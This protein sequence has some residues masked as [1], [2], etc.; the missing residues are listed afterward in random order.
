M[1]VSIMIFGNGMPN[2]LHI[3]TQVDINITDKQEAMIL[4][5]CLDTACLIAGE[6]VATVREIRYGIHTENAE[7]EDTAKRAEIDGQNQSALS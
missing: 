2:P 1:I 7:Q 5:T 4:S 3:T 6:I